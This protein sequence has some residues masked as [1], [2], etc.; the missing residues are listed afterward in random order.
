MGGRRLELQKLKLE[1]GR[2]SGVPG[3]SLFTAQSSFGLSG[4]QFPHSE[5][6]REA[7]AQNKSIILQ[8]RTRVHDYSSPI[9]SG[10]VETVHVC[11]QVNGL[12]EVRYLYAVEYYSATKKGT[13]ESF[14]GNRCT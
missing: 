3:S 2:V 12:K 7:R 9:H 8:G 5:P 4:S 14:V 10:Q 11:Q 1:W 6:M 13:V